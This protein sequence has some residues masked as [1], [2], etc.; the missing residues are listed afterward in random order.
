[1]SAR[2]DEVALMGMLLNNRRRCVAVDPAYVD[3]ELTR[4]EYPRL[5]YGELYPKLQALKARFDGRDLFRYPQS[6]KADV[7]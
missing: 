3:A 1:V 2:V 7:G 6:I 4:E 5:T